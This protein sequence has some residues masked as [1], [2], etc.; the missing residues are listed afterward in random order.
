MHRRKPRLNALRR[1]IVLVHGT[2]DRRPFENRKLEPVTF[3]EKNIEI[4]FR[5]A[6]GFV[7]AVRP[8][9]FGDIRRYLESIF[10]RAEEHGLL[11]TILADEK[12]YKQVVKIRDTDP[13]SSARVYYSKD[14][15]QAAEDIA[16]E[17]INPKQDKEAII[18]YS[19]PLGEEKVLL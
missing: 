12:D 9:K 11:V 10:C 14:I 17:Y 3:D 7:V 6:R 13:N 4:S 16:R 2:V 18:E 19:E 15:E 5:F 8:G 1:D